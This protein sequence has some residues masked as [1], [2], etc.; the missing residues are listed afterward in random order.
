M[1][2]EYGYQRLVKDEYIY[3]VALCGLSPLLRTLAEGLAR[4]DELV[5]C[6]ARDISYSTESVMKFVSGLRKRGVKFTALNKKGIDYI[7]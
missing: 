3:V 5:V 2:Q 7:L 4:E 6:K 1:L